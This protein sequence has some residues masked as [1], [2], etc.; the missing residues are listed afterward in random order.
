MRVGLTQTIALVCTA[1]VLIAATPGVSGTKLPGFVVDR[2]AGTVVG[3]FVAFSHN[4]LTG[5]LS[6]YRLLS[7]FGN[8]GDLVVFTQAK[9]EN[10]SRSGII[11]RREI[12][13]AVGQEM[14]PE[15]RF[16]PSM[17]AIDGFVAQLSLGIG[18]RIYTTGSTEVPI[19]PA[20]YVNS[21]LPKDTVTFR[22]HPAIEASQDPEPQGVAP[23]RLRGPDFLGFVSANPGEVR[24]DGETI[25]AEVEGAR[26]VDFRGLRLD[27]LSPER[28]EFESSMLE[29]VA[30][31][32]VASRVTVTEGGTGLYFMSV[33]LPSPV[34]GIRLESS[35]Q[36]Q[37]SLDLES[38]QR[39]IIVADLPPEIFLPADVPKVLLNG[40]R[41][42]GVRT[43]DELLGA[44]PD[45][46]TEPL[47]HIFRDGLGLTLSVWLPG[48]GD[49]RL[50]VEV[51]VPWFLGAFY[52][53]PLWLLLVTVIVSA[54][55][56]VTWLRLRRRR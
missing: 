35:S 42:R 2:D 50:S 44:A 30:L 31:G 49:W 45:G 33:S 20:S 14:G 55:F 8:E 18:E 47:T 15:L 48:A 27:G 22:L 40:A 23:I 10:A 37:I 12:W 52:G 21:S 28:S 19:R 41:P 51:L 38:S 56:L 13:F 53:V 17:I 5:E 16:F 6:D 36:N 9:L 3:S 39:T 29:A 34:A 46:E 32:D 25:T 26:L 54:A 24:T 11:A 7:R 1:V 43:L 4:N